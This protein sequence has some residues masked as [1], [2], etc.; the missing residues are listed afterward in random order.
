MYSS[1]FSAALTLS[2]SLIS[3]CCFAKPEYGVAM[4]GELKYPADFKH[5]DYVNPQAPKG[6]KLKRAVRSNNFDSFNPF[7]VKGVPAAGTGILYQSLTEHASDEAF[8]E[9][10]LI[11]EKIDIA[12]D[13]STVTFH[14]NPKAK[15]SDGIAITS[16]DVKYSFDMLTTN[17]KSAPFYS[18]YY[19]DVREV[20]IDSPTQITFN[21]KDDKNKELPLII[22]QMPILAEHYWAKADFGSATLD[23]PIGNGPYKIK[24]YDAGRSVTYV[25][26]E[27]YWAKDLPVNIGRHNFEEI[28]YEYYSDNTVALEAFKA[29]EYDYRME[30]SARN[31]A[32]AYEGKLFDSG[33]LVKKEVAHQR[34]SGMQAFI[35]NTRRAIFG[36]DRV[37]QA[38][39]LAFDFEWTNKNLFNSQYTRTQSFFENSELASSGLPSGEE[40]SLLKP[41]KTSLP[42]SVFLESYR[43]PST[44]KP[45]SLRANLRKAS[46]LLSEAG[47]EVKDKK[48]SRNGQTLN[49]EFLIFQKDFE[50]VIQPYLKNLKKLGVDVKIIVVDSTQYVNRLREFNFD[51]IASGFGQSDSPGNEQREYWH[52]S[53]ADQ[54]GSRNYA[55]INS[56][57]I[58]ALVEAVITAPDRAALIQRTRALDRALLSGHYVIPNWYNPVDRIAF[59]N[60][61]AHPKKTP[62]SGVQI[63][64]WWAAP[65][66]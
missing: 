31:W 53:R 45:S 3:A 37:R 58:D 54:P 63:D 2:L 48:R 33:E 43:A 14:I 12:D 65:K 15:F 28:T 29:G 30:T 47:W 19:A 66:Q 8:S 10:G 55:G 11:A 60:S 35:M 34:P 1:K 32:N 41:Y 40:L 9:Y 21:F 17:D 46:K 50:R 4:H 39:A 36:D 7:I 61:L 16:K 57:A 42:E 13:R 38:M 27:N 52:S 22:G 62:K 25:R 44:D 51:M 18:A 23:I 59:R 24:S 5:F 56:P 26:D 20:V 6:G 64:T 49:F